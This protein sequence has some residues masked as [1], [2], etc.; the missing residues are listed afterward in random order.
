ME[1][2]QTTATNPSEDA[3][4]ATEAYSPRSA[5]IVPCLLVAIP[6][7]RR[8]LELILP[9]QPEGHYAAAQR[10]E[11]PWATKSRLCLL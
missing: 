1:S 10:Q 5:L 2:R 6:L 4:S 7:S 8:Q 9:I 11:T 3:C